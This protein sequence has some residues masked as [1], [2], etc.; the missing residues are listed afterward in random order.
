MAEFDDRARQSRVAV[1]HDS[2]SATRAAPTRTG[3]ATSRLDIS[4]PTDP[5]EREAEWKARQVLSDVPI[6]SPASCTNCGAHLSDSTVARRAIPGGQSRDPFVGDLGAGRGLDQSTRSFFE[7]RFARDFGAVR[8]HTGPAA[9]RAAAAIN[10]Q[11]FTVGPDVAIGAGTTS[12]D[13]GQG[14]RLLAHELAHV[15][16]QEGRAPAIHRVGPEDPPFPYTAAERDMDRRAKAEQ[17]AKEQA[18][19]Q[20]HREWQA[21]HQADH[22]QFLAGQR[23]TIAQD[24][25]TTQQQLVEQRMALLAEAAKNSAGPPL[26]DMR[27]PFSMTS[28]DQ[29]TKLVIPAALTRL[30]ANAQQQTV[31]LRALLS[32]K[33]LTPEDAA[34]AQ[35]AYLAFFQTLIP[36]SD[37]AD[38]N[39]AER[40]R[41]SRS[42]ADSWKRQQYTPCPNCHTPSP[43]TMQE[44]HA[45]PPSTPELQKSLDL[46]AGAKT[47][48]DWNQAV[49]RFLTATKVMDGI[50]LSTVAADHPAAAGFTFARDL[51]ERQ[52]SLQTREPDAVRIRAVFYP[53]D[54]WVKTPDAEGKEVEIASGIPWYFYL[55]HTPTPSDTT[56]PDG[57]SW[58]LRDITSPKRPEVSY[59]PSDVERYLRL[60]VYSVGRPPSVLF[61]EA[62]QQ[63]RLSQGH[64]LLDQSGRIRGFPQNHRA[65]VAVGLAGRD[66]PRYRR[67]GVDPRPPAVWR[68]RPCWSG[69]ESPAP[70]SESRRRS[71]TCTRNPSSA[72]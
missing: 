24:I 2:G 46:V 27:A 30:W 12:L 22:K 53:E 62:Q 47:D 63:A 17:A 55:T 65:V 44:Y 21:S 23:T 26:P 6:D 45:P 39:E 48:A 8:L 72:S 60:G 61:R 31:V 4:R 40:E 33:Q 69:W 41:M 64:C 13:S 18:E 1:A 38:K 3:I 68:P 11:A 59:E 34:A 67:P 51:L 25:V 9:R 54:K 36:L 32:G 57:F 71:P 49:N 52:M 14:R 7:P 35:V 10:A 15:V 16:Q 42:L 56:Y 29:T 28:F 70:P 43:T 19:E 5:V 58:T 50:V 37:T 20:R 66:R